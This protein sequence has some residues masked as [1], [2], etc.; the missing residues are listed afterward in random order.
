MVVDTGQYKKSKKDSDRNCNQDWDQ[1]D[2]VEDKVN[3]SVMKSIEE[4]I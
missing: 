3:W 1:N 4:S 2:Y